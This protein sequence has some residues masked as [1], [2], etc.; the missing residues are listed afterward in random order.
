MRFRRTHEPRASGPRAYCSRAPASRELPLAATGLVPP[1]SWVHLSTQRSS[2][3]I[4]RTTATHDEP[5]FGVRWACRGSTYGPTQLG[6]EPFL[7]PQSSG[8]PGG[9][10]TCNPSQ[11]PRRS[12]SNAFATFDVDRRSST[13]GPTQ[14]GCGRCGGGLLSGLHSQSS[15]WPGGNNYGVRCSESARSTSSLAG[16]TSNG[17]SEKESS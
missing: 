13:E 7:R 10:S 9:D 8:W 2:Q 6:R 4:S 14:P 5:L 12:M 11:E 16:Y 1:N 15:G 3:P 17:V